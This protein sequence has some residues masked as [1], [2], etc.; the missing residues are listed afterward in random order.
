MKNF[1]IADYRFNAEMSSEDEFTF[2]RAG[3]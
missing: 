3:A 2:T 1:D